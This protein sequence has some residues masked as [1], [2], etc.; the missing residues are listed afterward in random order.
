MS[1]LTASLLN[2]PY[3]MG[4]SLLSYHNFFAGARQIAAEIGDVRLISKETEP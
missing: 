1:L 4:V 2:I 3:P